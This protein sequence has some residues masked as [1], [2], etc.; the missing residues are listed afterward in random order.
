MFHLHI[1]TEFSEC[2]GTGIEHFI[3]VTDMITN[4]QSNAARE[5]GQVVIAFVDS[6]LCIWMVG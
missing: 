5:E 1:S 2:F 3:R 4:P 6:N